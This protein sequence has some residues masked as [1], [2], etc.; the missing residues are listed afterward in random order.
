MYSSMSPAQNLKK[1]VSHQV[2]LKYNVKQTYNTCNYYFLNI[3]TVMTMMMMIVIV[4]N[5]VI[6]ITCQIKLFSYDQR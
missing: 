1:I 4:H 5:G 6:I 3:F 2:Y